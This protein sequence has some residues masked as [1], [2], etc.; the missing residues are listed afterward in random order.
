MGWE[1]ARGGK[2]TRN[3]CLHNR[4]KEGGGRLRLM[5]RSWEDVNMDKPC[6][7]WF[8]PGTLKI[9]L[10]SA[11]FFS[12]QVFLSG[13]PGVLTKYLWGNPLKASTESHGGRWAMLILKYS[14]TI[15]VARCV[16]L[17]CIGLWESC[18]S[19]G[20]PSR[21]LIPSTPWTQST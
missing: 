15:C 16:A 11:F 12:F 13:W 8:I 14:D 21:F 17:S 20:K 5:G 1:G 10:K 3:F 19:N 9:I 6:W 18:C 2:Q 7:K 4:E